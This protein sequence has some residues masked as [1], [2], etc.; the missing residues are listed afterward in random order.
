MVVLTKADILNGKQGTQEIFIS[1]LDKE[2]T[3]R[4]LTDGEYSEYQAIKKDMGVAKTNLDMG[5]LDQINNKG[6]E[7]EAIKK[8][9]NDIALDLDF[10]LI[11]QKTYEANCVVAAYGLSI[12]ENWHPSDVKKLTP[13]GVV[14]EIA[15]AVIRISGLQSPN[16][17]ASDVKDFRKEE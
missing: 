16:E 17:L 11:E 2:I 10:K 7:S 9:M 12:D 5:K 8:V 15:T 6:S 4:P 14:K 3:L 1:L 13:A